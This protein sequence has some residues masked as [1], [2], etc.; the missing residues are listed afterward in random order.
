MRLANDTDLSDKLLALWKL[1]YAGFDVYA[2]IHDEI[3]VQLPVSSGEA[4]ARK[5]KAIMEDAM[6]EVMG[7][8]I[9]A[10]CDCHVVDC[11]KK[12]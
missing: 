10:E 4:D 11:W 3:L 2:F 5:V 7:H 1:V 6:A 8:G 12:P 9:P